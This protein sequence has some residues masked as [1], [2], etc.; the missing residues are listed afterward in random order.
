MKFNWITKKYWK[1]YFIHLLVF[2]VLVICIKIYKQSHPKVPQIISAMD[3]KEGYFDIF[4]IEHNNCGNIKIQK[5]ANNDIIINLKGDEIKGENVVHKKFRLKPVNY[6][7]FHMKPITTNKETY[8]L[9]DTGESYVILL[10]IR[11]K[12]Y[13]LIENYDK[14]KKVN[15]FVIREL[16]YEKYEYM[17]EFATEMELHENACLS[18]DKNR[19]TCF[20][21]QEID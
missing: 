13:Y 7:D 10:K 17:L 4:S 9:Y 16:S 8:Y 5:E 21:E 19:Y 6:I 2:I 3:I 15:L 20:F 11:R 12:N 14:T 18:I 1:Y